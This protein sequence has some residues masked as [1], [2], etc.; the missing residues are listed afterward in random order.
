MSQAGQYYDGSALPP[1]ETLTGNIG[2]A[3]GPDAAFNVD[4]TGVANS[5]IYVDFWVDW[6]L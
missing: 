5:G 6:Q 1:I 2:G 3:V 4:T